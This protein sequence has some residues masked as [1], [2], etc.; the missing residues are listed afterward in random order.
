[1]GQPFTCS[2]KP[3]GLRFAM[4]MAKES[5][6]YRRLWGRQCRCMKNSNA[7][8]PVW[9]VLLEV[10]AVDPRPPRRPRPCIARPREEGPLSA[11]AEGL[12]CPRPLF[13]RTIARK[14]ISWGEVWERTWGFCGERLC[15]Y[16]HEAP[17]PLLWSLRFLAAES[18]GDF[19]YSPARSNSK[20]GAF[21][22][23]R[24][25][26]AGCWVHFGQLV[27]P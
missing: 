8:T 4:A 27:W 21:T 12:V 13:P 24:K 5:D 25:I 16:R 14:G 9:A 22:N 26:K 15:F 19:G 6:R 10:E 11:A 20:A 7:A 18:K 2:Q 23:T 17:R 1:M 3:S